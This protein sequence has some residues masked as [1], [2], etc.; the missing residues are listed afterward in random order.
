VELWRNVLLGAELTP[1]K[2]GL[3]LNLTIS[4]SVDF[5]RFPQGL[6]LVAVY[7]LL[8]VNYM[9]FLQCADYTWVKSKIAQSHAKVNTNSRG[10][11]HK[12]T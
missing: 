11:V 3:S 2:T 1:W 9:A 8:Q 12:V 4:N 7:W 6:L 5:L 10:P